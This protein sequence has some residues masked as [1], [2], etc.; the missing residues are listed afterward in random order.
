MTTNTLQHNFTTTYSASV[1]RT[2][3][4]TRF[5]NWC[6]AQEYNR[7]FW[8]GLTLVTHGCIITPLTAIMVMFSGNEVAIIPYGLTMLSMV[9]VLV[10]NLAALP[11]KYTI[12]VYVLSIL[13]DIAIIAAVLL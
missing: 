4:I 2:S 13:A 8:V 3:F 6:E 9:M 1:S 11:T 5:L 12:P 10:T 7:V